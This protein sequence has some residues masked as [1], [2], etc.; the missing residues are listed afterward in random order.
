N[1]KF[2]EEL[3]KRSTDVQ[4]G[5]LED[6]LRMYLQCCLSLCHLWEAN[7][8]AA[9]ILWDYY[10]KNLNSLFNISWLGLKSLANVRKNPLFNAGN[11]EKLLC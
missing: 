4:T 1:W 2:V 11:S 5:I 10:S 3:L 6:Q 8:T 9:T 7:L